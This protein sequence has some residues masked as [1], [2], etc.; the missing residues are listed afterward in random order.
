MQGVVGRRGRPPIVNHAFDIAPRGAA[1]GLGVG[2]GLGEAIANEQRVGL[3]GDVGLGGKEGGPES[4]D[5]EPDEKDID[6]GEKRADR[7]ME[8]FEAPVQGGATPAQPIDQPGEE[9]A[10]GQGDGKDQKKVSFSAP[11]FS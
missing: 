7:G 6:G 9:Q 8:M 11:V 3:P 1:K 10:A 4:D 2:P 5:G